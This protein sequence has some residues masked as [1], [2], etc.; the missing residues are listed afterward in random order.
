MRPPGSLIEL[1]DVA[2]VGICLKAL[3]AGDEARERDN[4]VCHLRQTRR[5]KALGAGDEARDG[6]LYPVTRCSLTGF[7]ALGAGDE[8][9]G[10][11]TNRW[12]VCNVTVSMPSVR[13]MR[14][15]SR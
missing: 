4:R 11:I 5:F 1:G 3:G 15:A 10:V 6:G 7:K 2:F 9:P 8:A 13:A 14:L 12:E